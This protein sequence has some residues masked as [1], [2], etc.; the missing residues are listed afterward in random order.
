[1]VTDQRQKGREQT[2]NLVSRC[3]FIVGGLAILKQLSVG[4]RIK[5]VST[6]LRKNGSSFSHKRRYEHGE[7]GKKKEP[8]GSGL[9]LGRAR[10]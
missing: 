3:S 6:I 10:A 8:R 7:G 1:M 4:S 2:L 9:K 5:Q